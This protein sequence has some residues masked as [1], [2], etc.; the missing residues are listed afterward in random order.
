MV[1]FH[2]FKIA[3]NLSDV[4]KK[5]VLQIIRNPKA[6]SSS[7]LKEIEELSV[8]YPYFQGAHTLVAIGNKAQSAPGTQKSLIKAALYATDRKYLK[9]L[10]AGNAAIG[11]AEP[12]QTEAPKAEPKQAKA[13]VVEAEPVVEANPVEPVTP[14]EQATEPA[15]AA[16]APVKEEK[17]E[18]PPAKEE[19]PQKSPPEHEHTVSQQSSSP[20]AEGKEYHAPDASQFDSPYDYPHMEESDHE[21]L[22]KQV[23]ANLEALKKSK[24]NYLET[25][26]DLEDAEF[27]EAQ[28][29]AVKKATKS[30]KNTEQEKPTQNTSSGAPAD[31]KAITDVKSETKAEAPQKRIT[32]TPSVKK[33]T[34][35]KAKKTAES[36]ALVSKKKVSPTKSTGK[37]SEPAKRTTEANAAK[38]T[39]KEAQESTIK[40]SSE[41][42]STGKAIPPKKEEQVNIIDAFIKKNPSIKPQTTNLPPAAPSKDLSEPSQKLKDELVSE[43]LALI[44][45]KQGKNERALEV[46]EKLILKIPEKKAYFAARIKEIKK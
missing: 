2:N 46:Y 6:I 28:A 27:E 5:E 35:I 39:P 7:Q 15:K 23:F 3:T 40:T 20:Q 22:L 41:G 10:L 37:T 24:N 19:T 11:S 33:K 21:N 1:I 12:M 17:T 18:T 25:E 13:P 42:K 38:S 45:L 34:A 9:E 43:N 31:K 4:N 29:N 26:K 36:K 30:A 32:P 16:A 8:D 14:P 44:L